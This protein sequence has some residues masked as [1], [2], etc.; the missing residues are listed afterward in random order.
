MENK[1]DFWVKCG[2]ITFKLN[3][4]M[5]IIFVFTQIL[6]KIKVVAFVAAEK[7]QN[8]LCMIWDLLF[9]LL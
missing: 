2:A 7:G 9:V 5:V 4:G 3:V 8:S 6:F 1:R